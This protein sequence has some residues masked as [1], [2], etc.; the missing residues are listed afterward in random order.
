MLLSIFRHYFE[1]TFKFCFFYDLQ[2]LYNTLSIHLLF[3]FTPLQVLLNPHFITFSAYAAEILFNLRTHQIDL[4]LNKIL[5][6]SKILRV[7][8]A[9]R[10]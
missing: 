3:L 1:M 6:F 5:K 7:R 4:W 9:S 8:M 2:L 10:H